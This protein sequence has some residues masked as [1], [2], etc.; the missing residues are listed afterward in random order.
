VTGTKL[1]GRIGPVQVDDEFIFPSNIRA[2]GFAIMKSIEHVLAQPGP[3]QIEVVTD[4]KFWIDMITVYMPRWV[5][6]GTPWSAKKNPDM[7]ARCWNLMCDIQNRSGVL[8]LRHVYSHG[9]DKNISADDKKWN[10]CVDR[11]AGE[12][13]KSEIFFD[14]VTKE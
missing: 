1:T 6:D 14:S 5:H 12:A 7:T 4:S 13:C 8:K 3:P 9:K 10:D 11:W 2:E